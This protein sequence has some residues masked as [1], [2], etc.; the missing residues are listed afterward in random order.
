MKLRIIPPLVMVLFGLLMYL[1]DRVL[2]VGEFDFFGR[3]T[4]TLFLMGVALLIMA[5]ALFQFSRHK[6]TTDPLDPEKAS[7]LVT[8]GI[9]R[10]TRN[11]MYLAMLVLLIV[12]GLR[13]GNAFNTLIAAGFVYY[14]NH[15][16]IKQEEEALLRLFGKPYRTYCKA[17]RR[18]F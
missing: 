16:Q 3:R 13:L 10:F 15:F 8:S 14:M 2:P 7:T 17:V 5:S 11:P 4:L 12:W 6:T 18:W 1:L 9:Y